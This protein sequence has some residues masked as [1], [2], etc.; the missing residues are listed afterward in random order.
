MC[1]QP[2]KVGE[3]DDLE[4][5]K[6]GNLYLPEYDLLVD[7]STTIG[8]TFVSWSGY[9]DLHC[10]T[11]VTGDDDMDRIG[12][13][14]QVANRTLGITQQYRS[15]LEKVKEAQAKGNKREIKKRI[16]AVEKLN[17]SDMDSAFQ[18]NVVVGNDAADTVLPRFSARIAARNERE[19]CKKEP[20]IMMRAV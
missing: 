10:T 8:I 13:S 15:A 11:K 18:A 3:L 17:A 2:L 12:C 9:Q 4:R 16:A 14:M 6:G 19:A 20:E 1:L 5:K 7:F